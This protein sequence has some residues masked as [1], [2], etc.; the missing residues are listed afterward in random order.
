MKRY[1]FHIIKWRIYD[2]NDSEG[3]KLSDNYGLIIEFFNEAT[4]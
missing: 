4:N 1:S 2:A 3:Y